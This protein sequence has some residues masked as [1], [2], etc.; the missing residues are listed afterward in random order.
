MRRDQ[1]EHGPYNDK[2]H[3]SQA[4]L[5]S[6]LVGLANQNAQPLRFGRALRELNY[7]TDRRQAGQVAW[8]RSQGVMHLQ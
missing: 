2:L 4:A 3:A 5:A 7:L 8:S 1:V 6:K